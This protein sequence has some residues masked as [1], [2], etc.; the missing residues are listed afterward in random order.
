MLGAIGLCVSFEAITGFLQ[1]FSHVEEISGWQ[2]VSGLNPE[3]VNIICSKSKESELQKAGYSLGF[4]PKYGDDHKT[5][6]FITKC[7]FEGVDFY[8]TNA[9]TY[10]FSNPNLGC[11][12]ADIQ[13]DIPQIMG[14]QRRKD[15]KF[16]FDAILY[17]QSEL[18]G[19]AE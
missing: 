4:S 1:N 12:A 2:D 13:T 17:F 18:Q 11:E 7:A 15:N 19:G 8:S 14:R 6:T 10:I 3:E 16:R 9:M 5:Y